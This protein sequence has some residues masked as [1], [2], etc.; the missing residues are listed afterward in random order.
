MLKAWLKSDMN[1][2][3]LHAKEARFELYKMVNGERQL[4]RNSQLQVTRTSTKYEQC[5]QKKIL[6]ITKLGDILLKQFL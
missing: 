4:Q 3:K 1:K 2:G 6:Q 5:Q